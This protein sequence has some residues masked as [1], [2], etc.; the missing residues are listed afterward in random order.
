MRSPFGSLAAQSP[1]APPPPLPFSLPSLPMLLE[2]PPLLLL[3]L[4]ELLLLLLERGIG[5]SLS[6]PPND[7]SYDSSVFGVSPAVVS[8]SPAAPLEPTRITSRSSSSSLGAPP[9]PPPPG[10]DGPSLSSP[11]SMP[12][13]PPSTGAGIVCSSDERSGG[14]LTGYIAGDQYLLAF[15]SVNIYAVSRTV[16]CG[17]K[18]TSWLRLRAYLSVAVGPVKTGLEPLQ[19]R[20]RWLLT[21]PHLVR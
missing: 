13:S 4:L 2:P 6:P 8:M 14:I 21:I 5:A 1:A 11:V 15:F 12:V 18:K 19:H 20:C 9:P 16:S 10:C 7:P 3:L 17:A